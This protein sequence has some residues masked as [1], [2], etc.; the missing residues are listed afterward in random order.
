MLLLRQLW[1]CAM[2]ITVSLAVSGCSNMGYRSTQKTE[3]FRTHFRPLYVFS[4]GDNWRFFQSIP[5]DTVQTRISLYFFI[6]WM[7]LQQQ[8]NKELPSFFLSKVV[9]EN[10]KNPS[11]FSPTIHNFWRCLC[12]KFFPDNTHPWIGNCNSH[13]SKQTEQ[14]WM[15]ICNCRS[16]FHY[17]QVPVRQHASHP[18][19][20]NNAE[21]S[22]IFSKCSEIANH[23]V[24][25]A[26]ICRKNKSSI[27]LAFF[28][29]KWKNM[30]DRIDIV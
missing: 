4:I 13:R 25:V 29:S 23:P 14:C 15:L 10:L 3:H 17:W 11:P 8:R 28:K 30:F 27:L 5:S 24:F 2:V 6:Q 7:L 1:R 19:L 18:W 12:P 20:P 26:N 16:W 21:N 9:V 22:M